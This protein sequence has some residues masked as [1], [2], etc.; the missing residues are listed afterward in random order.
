MKPGCEVIEVNLEEWQA[1]LER[2]REEPWDE[3]GYEKLQA[4]LRAFRLLTDLI[5][6]EDTTISRLRAVS[7]ETEHGEDE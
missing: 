2:A 6:E 3:E 4:A 7:G 1:L 5:G